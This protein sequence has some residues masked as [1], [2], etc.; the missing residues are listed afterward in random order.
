MELYTPNKSW[1][2]ATE[3]GFMEPKGNTLRFLLGGDEGIILYGLEKE[4]HVSNS[5]NPNIP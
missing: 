2:T 3:N 4:T 5:Q 1:L